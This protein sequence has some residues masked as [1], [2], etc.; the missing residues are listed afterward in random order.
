MKKSGCFSFKLYC[1][2]DSLTSYLANNRC[3]FPWR[4]ISID[5]QPFIQPALVTLL[6]G[7][8]DDCVGGFPSLQLRAG[9]SRRRE[10]RHGGAG[11]V[12]RHSDFIWHIMGF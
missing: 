2:S 11:E 1:S 7:S 4:S 10:L 6:F 5:F 9:P 8:V 12:D 3:L